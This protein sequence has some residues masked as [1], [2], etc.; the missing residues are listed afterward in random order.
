MI[1]TFLTAVLLCAFAIPAA[2]QTETSEKEPRRVRVGLGPQLAPSFPGSRDH[3]VR[4]YWDL[5]IARGDTPFDYEAPDETFGLPLLKTG[6]F[7]FGP[8]L[9]LENARR[10]KRVGAPVDEV[11]TTLEAGGFTQVWLTPALRIRAE[12]R[13]GVN[14]HR[15][16]VGAVG[17]DYVIREGDK[18]LLSLGPRVSLSDRGYQTAY[19]G[20]NVREATASGLPLYRPR[21]G[22]HAAGAIAGMHYALG[23]RWGIMAFAKYDRL[24]GDAGRSPLIR[25][26]GKRDQLS[27]GLGLTYTFGRR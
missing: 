6:D 3:S 10:R 2:A 9:N 13:Q 27:G 19:F 22:V 16:L 11:G 17:A 14:G 21:A 1:R 20:V 12:A 8:A 26:F 25:T 4:P 24:V 5:S 15:S 18:W 23:D 7:E